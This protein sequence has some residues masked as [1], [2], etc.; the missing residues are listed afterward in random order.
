MNILG[1]ECWG[2]RVELAHVRETSDGGGVAHLDA[3]LDGGVGAAQDLNALPP[4]IGRALPLT[5]KRGARAD[6]HAE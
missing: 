4:L 1:Q 6:V 3:L 5:V 2:W